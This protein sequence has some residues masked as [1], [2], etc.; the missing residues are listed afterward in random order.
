MKTSYNVKQNGL[1]FI[2]KIEP[3]WD[4]SVKTSK[5]LLFIAA[6]FTLLLKDSQLTL[7]EK[8]NENIRRTQYT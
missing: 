1:E 8:V 6:S 7:L 2:S 4:G 3:D 5:R